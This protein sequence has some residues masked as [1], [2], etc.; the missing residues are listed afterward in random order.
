[1]K[2]KVEGWWEL[3][4]KRLEEQREL[5]VRRHLRSSGD[6]VSRN[7]NATPTRYQKRRFQRGV[8]IHVHFWFSRAGEV[9]DRLLKH[10]L[11]TD[12]CRDSIRRD[13]TWG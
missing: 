9:T 1:M 3:R 4:G 5:K 6:Q 10:R 2:K 7:F 13:G 11:D 12:S 8:I